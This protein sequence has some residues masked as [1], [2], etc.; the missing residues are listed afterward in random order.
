MN[1]LKARA[2]IGWVLT[3]LL[4]LAF[5]AAA[6]GKLTG[7]ATQM[8]AHWGYPAWFATLIGI[9]ELAGAV[10]L[11]IPKTTRYAVLGLTV[12]MFGAAYTHLAN[13]EG[14]QVL[15]PIIFLVVLWAVWLLRRTASP[16]LKAVAK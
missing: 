8:F 16:A 9:L 13:H 10:G 3:V 11:L 4:A 5:L 6:A 2:I 1:L 12:I 14:L 7:A 15:R